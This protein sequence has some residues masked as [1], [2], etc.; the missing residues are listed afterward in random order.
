MKDKCFISVASLAF[1]LI[2]CGGG[3]GGSTPATNPTPRPTHDVN[4]L[5]TTGPA[6]QYIPG[7]FELVAFNMLNS[8]LR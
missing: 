7:S 8:T 2:G 3:G 6:P 4:A 1:L 5:Q